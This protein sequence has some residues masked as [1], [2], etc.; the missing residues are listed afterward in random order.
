VHRVARARHC[1]SHCK[2]GAA[3]LHVVS[4]VSI[5]T[6]DDGNLPLK[7]QILCSITHGPGTGRHLTLWYQV[8]T[9]IQT[10]IV[11]VRRKIYLKLKVW[12]VQ[13]FPV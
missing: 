5:Q 10:L 8:N 6:H 3:C 4:K 11:R 7:H 2:Q 13:L 1:G 9:L 12:E